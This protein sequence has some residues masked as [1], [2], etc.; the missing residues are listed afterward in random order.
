[1]SNAIKRTPV[2]TPDFGLE[3]DYSVWTP[4]T[5]VSLCNVNWDNNYRDVVAFG[6]ETMTVTARRALLNAHIDSLETPETR[7]ENMSYHRPGAPII[8]NIPYNK[9]LRY[10]YLR[11]SNAAQSGI[12]GDIRRDFYYFILDVKYK[13]ANATEVVLQL[14][15]FQTYFYDTQFGNCYIEH[16]HIAVANERQMENY[17]RTFLTVPEGHDTGSDYRIIDHRE[18]T[19]MRATN[20]G[21]DSHAVLILS[22]VDLGAD[23]GTISDP[24]QKTAEGSSFEALVSGASYYVFPNL[25]GFINFMSAMSIYPWIT[26]NILSITLIPSLHRYHPEFEYNP[27]EGVGSFGLTD[28]SDYFPR[29]ISYTMYANW[30]DAIKNKIPERYRHLN[31]L[32]TFPYMAIELTTWTATPVILKPESWRNANA[33][34]LER[35]TLTLPNQRVEIIPRSYNADVSAPAP[36]WIMPE[37]E[38]LPEEYAAQFRVGDDHGDWLDVKTM[39]SGFPTMAVL[40]NG[41]IGYLASNAHSIAQ[42]Y[43]SNSWAQQRAMGSN[44]QSYDNA[45][46]GMDL[47]SEL[48]KIGIGSDKA[49]VALQNATARD[50]MG[51]DNAAGFIG[52]IASGGGAS[53]A[54]GVA[55]GVAL[56]TA[57]AAAEMAI[58]SARNTVTSGANLQGQAVRAAQANQSTA[59]QNSTGAAVRDRNKNVGDWAAKGD[60]RNQVAAISARTQDAQLIAPSMSGQAGGETMN[61]VHNNVEVSVRW[62]LLDESNLKR[63]GEFWLRYGYAVMQSAQVPRLKVMTKF[64]Y[65]K[66]TE[67]Y[68]IA[69]NMPEGFKQVIRGIFEKGVTVWSDP[70]YI[71]VTDWADNAPVGGIELP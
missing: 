1:M 17:G 60:Y 6:D 2:G 35:S 61:I 9:V 3:F 11:A 45:T 67:T 5:V 14:D 26:Q 66:L 20:G 34:L 33:D 23:P 16:G 37:F 54:G 46:A 29:P 15:V 28:A 47:A 31:K 56:G 64:S 71:G 30:R 12:T 44:Q 27:D 70:A 42:Q 41:Q 22:T 7:I 53:S 21:D 49:S 63:V 4:G 25:T 51:I 36:E 13:S 69:S 43:A 48:T 55:A 18:N 24:N 39:I 10:N 19:I 8:V 68:L 59:A 38:G 57:G 58:R 65:W 62:K 50:M 32:L 40:N 52:G